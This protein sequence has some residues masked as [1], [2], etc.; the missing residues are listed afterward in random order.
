MFP[1]TAFPFAL[2]RVEE[3]DCY[4]LIGEVYVHRIMPGEPFEN[5]GLQDHGGRE[6]FIIA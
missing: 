3:P 4:E 5:G 2:Q 1:G 6:T